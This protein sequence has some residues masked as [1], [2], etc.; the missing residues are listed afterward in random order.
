MKKITFYYQVWFKHKRSIFES[1]IRFRKIYPHEQLILT[2]AGLSAIDINQYEKDFS[3][4]LQK[5]FNVKKI[6][7]ITKEEYPEM[8]GSGLQTIS[9][10]CRD[11][12]Y[13][14][15]E[16]W[17]DKMVSLVDESDTDIIFACSDDSIIMEKIPINY[18]VDMCGRITESS[19]W[20]NIEKIYKTFSPK[21]NFNK[22]IWWPADNFYMNYKK[23]RQNYT[24]KNKKLI[25]DFVIETYKG[26][27]CMFTDFICGLWGL[28]VFETFENQSY[29]F[30][31]DAANHIIEKNGG[32]IK[33]D[34]QVIDEYPE[35][36]YNKNKFVCIHSY[37][38]FR[39]TEI[40]DDMKK[41]GF[42]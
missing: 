34:Y 29:I 7:Y 3:N 30:Q 10:N 5:H 38:T 14:F 36:I 2:I 18:E 11:T 23:F 32:R 4:T 16:I 6:G 8:L 20:M 37:K 9:K 24:E 25:R 26:D 31:Y 40:T 12:W 33:A 1:L 17:L 39:N 35:D 28:L 22:F 21:L 13:D 42:N 19:E 27:I 41:I 15:N